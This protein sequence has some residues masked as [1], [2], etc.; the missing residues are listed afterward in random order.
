MRIC[1]ECGEEF[2]RESEEFA[3]FVLNADLTPYCGECGPKMWEREQTDSSG[4]S[5]P[6]VDERY[7]SAI[8]AADVPRRQ[9]LQ[10]VDPDPEV[11]Q[12]IDRDWPCVDCA[13]Y[14]YGPTRTGKTSQVVAGLKRR[15]RQMA[16]QGRESNAK[17]VEMAELVRDLK[18]YGDGLED[19]AHA[20]VLALDELGREKHTDKTAEYVDAIIRERHKGCKP[21]L[22]TSNVP[23]QPKQGYDSSL[24][25]HRS[26][27]DRVIRRIIDMVDNGT[28][29]EEY[30]EM[31]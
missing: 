20:D 5:G 2:E 17:F 12:F 21:T 13:L 30:E 31:Q 3:G 7:E 23:L 24:I 9:R 18:P 6:T 14:A 26:Y 16:E 8:D 11:C 1:E 15:V 19:Y 29:V 10:S 22:L 28:W 27:D 25:E 4:D